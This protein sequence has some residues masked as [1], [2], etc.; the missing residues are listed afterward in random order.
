MSGI[1]R[2]SL[3]RLSP[4]FGGFLQYLDALGGF[5]L[6]QFAGVTFVGDNCH[7]FSRES[8]YDSRIFNQ[9][10]RVVSAPV[11]FFVAVRFKGIEVGTIEAGIPYFSECQAD[12]NERLAPGFGGFSLLSDSSR[13]GMRKRE[14][15]RIEK[16]AAL[17]LPGKLVKVRE[18]SRFSVNKTKPKITKPLPEF[19]PGQLVDGPTLLEIL[20]PAKCR[21]TLR[22]LRQ[23]Q[24]QRSVPFI[25]AG[26][27]VFFDPAKVREHLETANL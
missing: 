3:T 14:P 23:Q 25:K 1:V 7:H 17:A 22:W 5:N 15:K 6:R 8:F 2:N 21:P 4:G 24:A 27:L 11:P 26:R 20:F 13:F 10:V 9:M 19:S 16:P 18:C 12:F